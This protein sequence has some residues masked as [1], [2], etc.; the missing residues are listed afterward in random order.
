LGIEAAWDTKCIYF[1]EID[2]LSQSFIEFSHTRRARFACEGERYPVYDH[3]KRRWRH[4]NFF[5]HECHLYSDIQRVNT[6]DSYIRLVD[7]PWAMPGS[8]FTML[9]EPFGATYR[10]RELL[11]QVMEDD[12]IGSSRSTFLN[13]WINEALP[14]QFKTI[15][16]YVSMLLQHRYGSIAH[17]KKVATNAFAECVNLK[18]IK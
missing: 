9:F 18:I 15:I 11:K 13:D 3:Q 7:V 16:D 1:V 10:L 12:A 6:K 8:S 2:G 14:S 4:L 5:Q 17:F